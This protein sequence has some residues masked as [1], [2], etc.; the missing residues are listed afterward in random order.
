MQLP[1]FRPLSSCIS[2]AAGLVLAIGSAQSAK[3]ENYYGAWLQEFNPGNTEA[4]FAKSIA[5]DRR[6][7]VI[8]T[9]R[10]LVSGQDR[11][12]TAKY[13]ALDGHLVWFKYEGA[14]AFGCVGLSVA[15]DS[16][17]NAVVTGTRYNGSNNDYFT[18]KY[19]GV[20]GAPL[21]AAPKIYDG[22]AGGGDTP[23]K[24]V[25]DGND[26]VIVTGR[27]AGNNGNPTFDDIVTIKYA[28]LTGAQIG[29]VDRYTTAGSRDD[30]PGSLAID[31]NNNI[32]IAGTAAT[33]S[34]EKRFYVR[35]LT[36]AMAFSWQ[37]APIDT[38]DADG[39]KGVAIDSNDNVIA[40]GPFFDAGNH[41]GLFTIKLDGSDGTPIW[42]TQNPPVGAD[43]FGTGGATSV[44]VGPDNN[45]VVTGWV[46]QADGTDVIR[47]IKYTSGGFFGGATTL[48]D[49]TD[50]GL[51]LGD[52][53]ARQVVTDGS[54]NAY[55][56]GETNNGSNGA[57]L[58]FAKY[59]GL[60][61]ERVY[62][63]NYDGTQ[64]TTDDGIGVAVDSLSNFAVLGCPF[65]RENGIGL[66]TFATIKLNRFIALTGDALPDNID[67]VE[68]DATYSAGGT[69]AVSS[70]G[71]VV[72]A[73]SF[74]NGRKTTKAILHE[75]GASLLPAVQGE[76][77]PIKPGQEPGDWVSFSDPVIAPDGDYAFAAK[78]TGK[79]ST[80]VWSNITGTLLPALR[81]GDAIPG[82]DPA[83]TISSIIS[84]SIESNSLIA[85]V[86]VTGLG[87][88]NNVLVRVDTA[89][90][91]TPIL[92]TG[93]NG[94]DIGGTDFTVSKF[95]V[96]TPTKLSAT[97]GRWE[98]SSAVV[99]RASVFDANNKKDKR[100]VILRVSNGG[101][102]TVIT[103]SGALAAGVEPMATYKSFGLPSI[104][105]GG[106]QF[107]YLANL[108]KLTGTVSGSND[109]ALVYTGTGSTFTAFAREGAETDVSGIESTAVYSGFSE[110]IINSVGNVAFI[111]NLKGPDVGIKKSAVIFGNPNATLQKIAR[112]G[113]TAPAKAPVLGVEPEGETF[114]AGFT[115]FGLANG[116]SGRPV[117]IAK[118]KG[119]ASGKDNVA[120]FGMDTA[121]NVRRLLRTGDILGVNDDGELRVVKS[122]TIMKSTANVVAANRALSAG[123]VVVLSV[124]FTDRTTALLAVQRRNSNAAAEQ[125][126]AAILLIRTTSPFASRRSPSDLC[127]LRT[128][129]RL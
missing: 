78:V 35:K 70:G 7:N 24:V 37:I 83:G 116:T 6:G 114:Y 39:A 89:G 5:M 19:D 77:A 82:L 15:A 120:L 51:A 62:A 102:K 52:S 16:E 61:G 40:T 87:S 32:V 1:T 76:A 127:R 36:S 80:G 113:E 84:Y 4:Q 107:A 57:D 27:S 111:G 129:L 13:D 126:A 55:I 119:A 122:M 20:S 91:V 85:L 29:S 128:A 92:R 30:Y 74:K 106:V 103:S 110:P 93:K 34:G 117:F 100:E 31:S 63:A 101:T 25:V 65:R 21:W 2:A 88:M 60:T 54:S 12:Y 44:A 125:F 23:V 98:T 123:G 59:D 41:R 38:G 104:G 28:K 121:G 68:E 112:L 97:D 94:V 118:L 72:A 14:G 49:T 124:A 17:G 56:V 9:G 96:L 75:G 108:N 53:T 33:G 109:T 11:M 26:D 67:G 22:T 45:P 47:T 73:V 43:T 66:K 48:W 95:S 58:Y 50:S 105:V 46:T 79:Q 10:A 99:V 86:K 42:Q 71:N 18:L 90:T 81:K 115:G 3:A 69:P 8:V 64:H